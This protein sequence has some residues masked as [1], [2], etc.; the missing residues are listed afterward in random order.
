MNVERCRLV[1]LPRETVVSREPVPGGNTRRRVVP[2]LA[3]GVVAASLSAPAW[4]HGDGDGH[5][6]EPMQPQATGARLAA[7]SH[8]FELVAVANGQRLTI[9]LDRFADTQAV[10]EEKLAIDPGDGKT[11]DAVAAGDGVYTVTADW[12]A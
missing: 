3:I 6:A 12:V 4:A 8:D 10:S 7:Q 5:D 2:L 11:I 1:G 9:Y